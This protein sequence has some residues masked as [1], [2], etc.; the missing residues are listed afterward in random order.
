MVLIGL[1]YKHFRTN[2]AK[3]PAHVIHVR[4]QEVLNIQSIYFS[5]QEYQSVVSYNLIDLSKLEEL[6]KI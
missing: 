1:L 5:N 2:L 4:K 3:F 6:C